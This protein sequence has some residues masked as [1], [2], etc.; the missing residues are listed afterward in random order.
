MSICTLG[1]IG[2]VSAIPGV[3]SA[4]GFAMTNEVSLI[5]YGGIPFVYDLDGAPG[6]EILWLQSP[7]IFHSH[8]FDD[9]PWNGRIR[10]DERTHFC[11]TATTSSGKIL[12]QIGS[13]WNGDRPFITHCGERGLDCAD[14]DGDGAPEIVC[15]RNDDIVLIDGRSGAIE[16][17][18]TAPADNAQ[19]VR[20]AHTGPT[21]WTIL[22]KNSE[23]VLS[24]LR[25]RES[26]L[27]LRCGT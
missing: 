19:I 22:A 18:V 7:G 1:I 25:I 6:A 23:S 24:A 17:S 14:L 5:D 12:W 27:V 9:G 11:L 26:V 10:E 16:K 4:A 2:L 3:A 21:D 15:V 13:P 20:I 8:V